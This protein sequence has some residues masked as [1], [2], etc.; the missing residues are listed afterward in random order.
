MTPWYVET[1]L[2]NRHHVKSD[3]A[4][5]SRVHAE[6]A[7]IDKADPRAF[8]KTLAFTKHKPL[9]DL[10][11]STANYRGNSVAEWLE[12]RKCRDAVSDNEWRCELTEFGA[13]GVIADAELNELMRIA[14][15]DGRD[16]SAEFEF[17][18]SIREHADRLLRETASE[19]FDTAEADDGSEFTVARAEVGLLA[20]YL[21]ARGWRGGEIIGG[22]G[23]PLKHK[24]VRPGLCERVA[25]RDGNHRNIYVDNLVRQPDSR[26]LSVNLPSYVVDRLGSRPAEKI[27]ELVDA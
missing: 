17:I 24:L 25:F 14:M 1:D 8:N 3:G 19:L 12:L 20:P 2:W 16:I 13:R 10:V 9:A 26:R 23:E 18:R 15:V 7:I 11:A 5:S 6:S 22:D 21:P 27:A 4:P